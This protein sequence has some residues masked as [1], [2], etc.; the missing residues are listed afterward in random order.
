MKHSKEKNTNIVIIRI[1]A[2][3]L[4]VLGTAIGMSIGMT[5]QLDP[6]MRKIFLMLFKIYE[7]L[8]R[9]S[10]IILGVFFTI[11]YTLQKK[12]T[13]SRFRITSLI[14]FS[15][16]AFTFLILLPLLTRFWDLYFG[17]SPFPWST[18]PLQLLSIRSYFG[19]SFEIP[20]GPNGVTIILYIYFGYQIVLFGGTLLL[21]RRWHCSMLCLINGAHA[22]SM[23]VALPVTPHNKKRPQSKQIKPSLRKI[24]IAVQLFLFSL[25]MVL[26]FFWGF[27]AYYMV[28]FVSIRLLM[29]VEIIKYFTLELFIFMYLWLFIGGRGYCYYCPVGF[30]LGLI[31]R[32]VGQKIETDLTHCTNCNACNDACKM[33]VDVVASVQKNQPVETEQ[34]TGCGLCVD[35]CPT[36]NLRYT[37][38]FMDWLRREK[39][40]SPNYF[41]N[42]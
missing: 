18:L 16:M 6:E 25:N 21:G 32:G 38:R 36:H 2:I 22:E 26:I 1:L 27:F 15:L 14:S 28:T 20:Y 5:R 4:I 12:G 41:I 23:G 13:L 19:N 3:G 8:V 39:I 42:L 29:I 24:L 7:N 37:T 10:A 9:A 33:S 30:L 31:G 35:S 34:C 40:K 17:I 11:R